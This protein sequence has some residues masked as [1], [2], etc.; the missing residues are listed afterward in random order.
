MAL[1]FSE[2]GSKDVKLYLSYLA[3]YYGSKGNEGCDRGLQFLGGFLGYDT[4][5]PLR[6]VEGF[7]AVGVA[8]ADVCNG[9]KGFV[10]VGCERCGGKCGSSRVFDGLDGGDEECECRGSGGR[11]NGDDGSRSGGR[12]GDVGCVAGLADVTTGGRSGYVAASVGGLNGVLPAGKLGDGV[13]VGK[14]HYK[15]K[16]KR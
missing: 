3:T 13:P 16:K 12:Q 2:F 15:N 11:V 10:A 4:V 8:D 14:H 6:C 5:S 1:A 9:S 7:Q